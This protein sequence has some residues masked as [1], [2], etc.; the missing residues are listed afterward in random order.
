MNNSPPELINYPMTHRHR[1]NLTAAAAATTWPI[2]LGAIART[3]SVAR[4]QPEL[5]SSWQ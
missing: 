3:V 2:E 5:V 1:L 4:V